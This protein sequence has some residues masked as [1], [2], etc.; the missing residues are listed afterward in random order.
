MPAAFTTIVPE[1][2]GAGA[3]AGVAVLSAGGA[4]GLAGGVFAA[5]SSAPP[6]TG[7][8][9]AA[10]S[11]AAGVLSTTHEA[12]ISR[13]EG[14]KTT[15]LMIFPGL[16]DVAAKHEVHRAGDAKSGPAPICF[17]VLFGID[18]STYLNL[19]PPPCPLRPY[20]DR[21]SSR[22][23]R[24]PRRLRIAL[25]SQSRQASSPSTRFCREEDCPAEGS[26]YGCHKAARQQFYARPVIPL[27]RRESGRRG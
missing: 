4:D 18:S 23:F 10:E 27:Q 6:A 13:I 1:G 8:L 14:T 7:A 3:G 5:L 21:S 12:S 24:M 9:L 20:F 15:D 22:D 11:P 16:G 2:G 25:R 26:R 19:R 17:R